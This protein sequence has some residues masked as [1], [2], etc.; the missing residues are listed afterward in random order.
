MEEENEEKKRLA[1]ERMEREAAEKLEMNKKM[2]SGI[3][4]LSSAA[5]TISSAISMLLTPTHGNNIMMPP[6]TPT[7]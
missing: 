7:D 1:E 5:S 6:P 2:C 4:S 3:E